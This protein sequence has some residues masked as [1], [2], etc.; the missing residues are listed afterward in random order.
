[1]AGIYVY[2]D[3]VS[4]AAELIG[5]AKT[6]GP[7]ANAVVL[8][9]ESGVALEGSGAETV[10]VLQGA[11]PLPESYA[12]SIAQFLE[13][14]G[15]DLFVVGATARGR[16]LAAQVAGHLGCGLVGDVS[17][18]ALVDGRLSAERL[19]YGGAVVQTEELTGLAVVTVASG[20]FTPVEGNAQ[21]VTVT[22][23]PDDRLRRV[24]SSPIAKQSANVADAERVVSVG[25]GL[26]KKEDLQL[27]SE[28]ADALQAGISCSRGVAEEREWLPQDQYVGISGLSIKPQLYLAVGISGQV[29]HV[30]GVR[31]T[32]VI[33]AV[34]KDEAA[35][36]FKVCDYG[37]VGDLYEVVPMLTKALIA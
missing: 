8:D 17:A 29:Q 13:E 14:H 26:E 16:D 12:K 28:L 7:A 35:P 34:N 33:V 22:V 37:I 1:M 9:A 25:L 32:K 36:I 18:I 2:S 27:I 10:Y 4:L 31:E 6:C 23:A 20:R 3:D 15:A 21:T 5:F 30:V 11:N 24:G 19:I